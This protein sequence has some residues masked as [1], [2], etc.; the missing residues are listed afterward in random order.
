MKKSVLFLVSLFISLSVFSQ[1]LNSDGLKM[2]KEL[3]IGYGSG[4]ADKIVYEYDENNIMKSVTVY[5]GQNTLKEKFYKE[6]GKIKHKGY[7]EYTSYSSYDIQTDKYGNITSVEVITYNYDRTPHR[8]QICYFDYVWEQNQFRLNQTK[9]NYYGY[10]R[11]DKQFVKSSYTNILNTV[12][13]DGLIRSEDE[14][15]S[16]PNKELLNDT[17]INFCVIVCA[18]MFHDAYIDTLSLTDWINIR[19]R[20]LP[21]YKEGKM[22]EIIYKYDEKGNLIQ[23]QYMWDK[24]VL[25]TEVNITYLN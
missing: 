11:E 7:D 8:K 18:S 3:T 22:R 14:W 17:N 24:K 19:S 2:V 16:E 15:N 1:R 6:G 21:K 23:L 5:N 9:I 20:F 10:S 13:D 4:I 25:Q 12:N